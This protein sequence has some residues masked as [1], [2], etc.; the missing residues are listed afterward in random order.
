MS[1]LFEAR[2]L[3]AAEAAKRAEDLRRAGRAKEA[4]DAY[5]EA[6][7]PG[8]TVAVPIC[9]GLARCYR[10]RG[11]EGEAVRWALAA[12][13]AGDDF[14]VWTSAAS[15]LPP[16]GSLPCRRKASLALLGSY[17]TQQFVP[18]LRLAAARAGIDLEIYEAPYGQYTQEV[19]DPHSGLWKR[20]HNI[21][22]F[23]VHHGDV[24]L[25][26]S[27]GD[28]DAE[29]D[30]EVSRWKALWQAASR[31]PGAAVV[32]HNFAL[33]AERPMGHLGAR[34]RGA[35]QRMLM[36]LNLRLAEAAGDSVSLVDCEWLSSLIGKSRWFSPRYWYAS[37]HAVSLEALPLLARHTAAVIAAR[38]GLTRKCLVLDL[39]N[40]LWGGVAAEDGLEGIRLGHGPDG[41]AFAAFQEFARQLKNAGTLL[42]V[43]SKNDEPVA[44]EVFEKHAGMRLALSD[45]A[46]FV[47]NWETKPDNLRRIARTLNIGLDSLVFADDNPAE[48][49]A[50]RRELPEVEVLPLPDDP[51]LLVES[52]A[53]C[54]FFE[55]AAYTPED[56]G[57][58]E[59]YAARA[60]IEAEAAAAPSLEE[61]QRGLAMQ[62]LVQPFTGETLP[63][64]AQLFGKTN[65]FNLTTRR[66]TLEE[67][68]A[69]TLRPDCV[70]FSLRLRDKFAD[71]GLVAVMLA[72]QS[73]DLIEIDSWLMS[74]RVIG[75][76]VEAV[77]LRELCAQAAGRGCCRLRGHYI[78][79]AKNAL[80]ADLF[81]GFGF[82]RTAERE[83]GATE[84]EFDLRAQPPIQNSFIERVEDPAGW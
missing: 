78:P 22:L 8:E 35:R 6:A 37:K 33:P 34:L 69:F 79:T 56:A 42:A 10:Q 7:G 73:G 59:Q 76:T 20:D 65:Q 60:A 80:V 47:A 82:R 64:I 50:V 57:R 23:A 15:L 16:H 12:A 4:I 58:T 18:L 39:D 1:A 36:E 53:R 46:L 55:S 32:Q 13:D 14:G 29:L 84:W 67:L 11:E 45:I 49:A 71:H 38:L 83:G 72:F 62:A 19:L 2:R 63:R 52:L 61:F 43:C 44:R 31:N 3:G 68:R 17:T 24:L 70:H 25:P 5:L 74:C 81:A 28:P 30:R 51:S 9:L 77:M 27:T 21:V 41:E 66:H 40:T 75:R 48:R 54:S 26:E